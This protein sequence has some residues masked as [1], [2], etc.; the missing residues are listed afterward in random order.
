VPVPVVP[1]AAAHQAAEAEA[2]T[3]ASS[4]P[5]SRA[6]A[7]TQGTASFHA[8]AL[9]K[10]QQEQR[11]HMHRRALSPQEGRAFP[12]TCL[13]GESAF[14]DNGNRCK[15]L[16]QGSCVLAHCHRRSQAAYHTRAPGIL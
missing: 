3:R 9:T 12:R 6:V 14:H 11:Q 16:L 8:R 13:L 5:S 2:A 4:R 10:E 15:F 7:A 1:T